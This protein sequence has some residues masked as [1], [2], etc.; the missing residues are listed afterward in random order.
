[1]KSLKVIFQK[2]MEVVP[3]VMSFEF[4]LD[5][6]FS[7][8]AGQFIKICFDP[9]DESNKN[10]NKFLSLSCVSGAKEIQVTKKISESEFSKKL[11]SLQPGDGVWIKGPM[12]T[13]VYPQ[14]ADKVGFL[15]GG[16]GIT[17]VISM[18]EDLAVKQVKC[19]VHLVYGNWKENLI[20]FKEKLDRWESGA[21]ESLK[22][23]HVL[24]EV[25]S[26]GSPFVKGF[27]SREVIEACMP[28]YR[29]RKIYILGPPKMV[30]T[31]KSLCQDMGISQEN[32]KTESFMGY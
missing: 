31:M 18:L 13:C 27:I 16:I 6:E 8:V 25:E 10:L 2:K 30:E 17:P 26:E 9:A 22:V 23:T 28:D 21:L 12:G 32:M 14:D 4:L 11:Q 5:E 1:M 15:V 3:G 29:Q 20:A 24:A 19:D 7:F